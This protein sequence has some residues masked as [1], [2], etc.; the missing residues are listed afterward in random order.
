[1]NSFFK[2]VADL[3]FVAAIVAGPAFAGDNVTLEPG[4]DR[5]GRDYKSFP[6]RSADPAAC[7]KACADDASCRSYTLTRPGI[8][9]PAAMCFLKNGVAASRADTCC[10]SGMKTAAGPSGQSKGGPIVIAPKGGKGGKV[11]TAPTNVRIGLD[12]DQNGLSWDWVSQG[13]FP[14]A[15]GKPAVECQFIKDIDG[16]HV[17]DASGKFVKTLPASLREAAIGKASTGCYTVTAFKGK[18]ESAKSEQVCVEG[19]P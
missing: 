19:K 8:K 9:G 11:I 1:M 3:A 5:T 14:G 16:F 17:A 4:T 7:Q 13:C 12:P 6:V 10:T 18:V 15:A 2:R